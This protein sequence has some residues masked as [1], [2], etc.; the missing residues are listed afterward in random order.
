M[1]CASRNGGLIA[2]HATEQAAEE[3]TCL[4]PFIGWL[5]ARSVIYWHILHFKELDKLAL[6]V[7]EE[8]I[9]FQLKILI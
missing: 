2:L 4:I 7:L 6:L 3:V 9:N 5:A 1:T 8:A